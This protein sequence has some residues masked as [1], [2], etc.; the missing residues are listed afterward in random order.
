[1]MAWGLA[2][3][4]LLATT[5]DGGPPDFSLFG[6]DISMV[7]RIEALGGLY[8]E[9]GKATDPIAIFRHNGWNVARLRLFVDP[10]G[11]N[12]VVNDLSYT[13]ALAKRVRASGMRFLLDFHYSDTWADPGHQTKPKAWDVPPFDALVRKVH[14]YTAAV[15]AACE[16]NGT[17]P[18]IVQIGNEITPGFLWPDGKLYGDGP[19]TPEERW[20][21]FT[22]LL[23]AG[24]A[25]ARET[26]CKPRV[27]VHIDK[28]G[29]AAS[30]KHFFTRL[31]EH[32]VDF[33]VIGLSYYPWW[34]GSLADLRENLHATAKAFRKD[35]IVVETAYPYRGEHWAK[36]PNMAWPI[37]PAGQR[38]FLADVVTAV[39]ET[40]DGRGIGVVYWYPESIRVDGLRVW[41]GGSSALF[42][43]DGNALPAMQA[44]E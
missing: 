37:S 30:T 2:L 28:G 34:H 27:M 26:K 32:D 22:T 41:N 33:D 13:L 14:D 25:A 11:R 8:R 17:P 12:A 16:R 6:G 21:R 4:T 42:D 29:K 38:A 7:S 36:K 5:A 20:Q 10:D 18:C 19:G 39:R 35:I 1:M 23:K 9:N 15:L 44:G 43:D 24:I 3:T 40:P 31:G